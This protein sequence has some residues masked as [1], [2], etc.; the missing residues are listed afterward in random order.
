MRFNCND[1][2]LNLFRH[3][4]HFYNPEEGDLPLSGDCVLEL[5]YNF[6]DPDIG[7][8]T[9]G[10][11]FIHWKDIEDWI[12]GME[13]VEQGKTEY[14]VKY[15]FQG[16]AKEHFLKLLLESVDDK[17]RFQLSISD[18]L[19]DE[20]I[21][22]DQIFSKEEWKSYS[23]EFRTW[24][25]IFQYQLGDYVRTV[26]DKE[27]GMKAGRIGIINE[28]LADDYLDNQVAYCVAIREEGCDELCWEGYICEPDEIELLEKN[29]CPGMT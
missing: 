5:Y 21:N 28:I 19:T 16:N 24:N 20:Y 6:D 4:Y 12:H 15:F 11:E 13:K 7:W 17:L 9:V 8:G 18:G 3:S 29:K 10:D 2:K 27:N 25:E 1:T 14:F 26:T 22:I 23:D